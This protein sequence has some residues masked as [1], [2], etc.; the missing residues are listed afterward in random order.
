MHSRSRW[1]KWIM[2]PLA[3]LIAGGLTAVSQ[4]LFVDSGQRLG[5]GATWGVALGDVDLDGDLDAVVANEDIGGVVWLNDS[6]GQFT[7]SGQ[8]LSVGTSIALADLD[9]DDAPDVL[10]GSWERPLAV[11]WNNGAG[12]FSA[13]ELPYIGSGCFALGVGDLNGDAALDVFVGRQAADRLLVNNGDRTFVDS[14]QRFGRAPTAGVAVGDI[15]SDGDLDVVAAGW[16]EPGHVWANDGDGVLTSRCEFEATSL[17]IHGAALVDYDGDGDLDAFFAL[18]GGIC[19]RNVWL[20][21][22]TGNL[23]A[24]GF[25]FGSLTTQGIAVGDL[26]QD[27]TLDVVL[28][29]GAVQ[30]Q[31]S[32][33]WLGERDGFTDSGLRI[34]LGFGGGIATGDLDG[35]GDLDL[36]IG[37]SH[38]RSY[39]SRSQPQPNEVWFNTTVDR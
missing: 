11:W 32:T 15:D 2:I 24:E 36:F 8:R 22:G 39:P 30:P 14:G 25:N 3:I 21:D 13:G 37:F 9:G 12:T 18:A 35:D 38:Y 19:C 10:I 28:A 26:N 27:G 20:N 31:P 4:D 7:D 6:R 33:V 1:A 5:E 34:G 17:H 16:D 29:I 23:A